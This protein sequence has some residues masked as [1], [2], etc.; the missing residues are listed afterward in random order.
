MPSRSLSKAAN[1]RGTSSSQGMGLLSEGDV[2]HLRTTRPRVGAGSPVVVLTLAAQRPGRSCR[3]SVLP[4]DQQ[5]GGSVV[6]EL[7]RDTAE[8]EAPAP[9]GAVRA[10]DDQLGAVLVG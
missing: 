6:G 7:A 8:R 3:R 9:G 4:D 10:H 2:C 1:R 5:A